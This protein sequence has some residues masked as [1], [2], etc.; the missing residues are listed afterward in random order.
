MDNILKEL[1]SKQGKI[2]SLEDEI[3]RLDEKAI[4]ELRAKK[5]MECQEEIKKTNSYRRLAKRNKAFKNIPKKFR[6]KTMQNLKDEYE[7]TEF[8]KALDVFVKSVYEIDNLKKGIYLYGNA[9]TG[10]TSILSV[11]GQVLYDK[12]GKTISYLTEEDL[13]NEIQET[14]KDHSNK[15][16]IDLIKELAKNEIILIDELGQ[17]CK[18]R[19]LKDLKV[20]LDEIVNNEH[21]IFITSNY[22]YQALAERYRNE[23]SDNK[24]CEQVVD[25]LVGMTNPL[26]IKGGSRR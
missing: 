24:L 11:F 9:G 7:G 16:D 22:N 3:N 13:K 19:F 4:E 23:N 1:S 10:K 8:H 20:F 5:E 2:F 12:K 21:L 26:E 14:F 17:N 6:G 15:T 18:E 25:R